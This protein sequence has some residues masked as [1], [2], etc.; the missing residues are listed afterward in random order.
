MK[1]IDSIVFRTE[2]FDYENS[3]EW[4]YLGYKPSII[5][6]SA[7]WCAPCR[8][9][10]P[11]M[12]ELSKEYEGQINIYKVDTDSDSELSVVFGIRSI[13]TFLFIPMEGQPSM[14]SGSMPKSNFVKVINEVLKVK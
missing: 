2:I 14:A 10:Y 6:F 8:S 7:S 12:E 4:K 3:K 5:M 13:P 1:Q 11:V 9:M